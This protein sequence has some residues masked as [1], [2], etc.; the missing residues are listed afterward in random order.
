M[1]LNTHGSKRSHAR[2][3]TPHEEPIL[4]PPRARLTLELA[5]SLLERTQAFRAWPT[6]PL[7]VLSSVGA[8]R[9]TWRLPLPPTGSCRAS[10]PPLLSLARMVPC[11]VVGRK[12][13]KVSWACPIPEVAL[14]LALF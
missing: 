3:R 14:P 12:P 1:P 4:S 8:H 9:P 13:H 7:F 11:R 2:I 5:H 10:I 6:Q